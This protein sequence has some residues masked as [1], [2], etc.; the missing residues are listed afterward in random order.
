MLKCKSEVYCI[1]NLKYM[2]TLPDKAFDL[3]ICDPPYGININNNMGR[4]KGYKNSDYKKV[5]WDSSTPN[6]LYFN[7]LF[8]ISNKAVVWGG[9]LLFITTC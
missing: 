1:D 8:R 5:V 4:R 3:A 6:D 9:Q 7:E 2:A